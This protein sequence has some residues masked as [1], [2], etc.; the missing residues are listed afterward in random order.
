MNESGNLIEPLALLGACRETSRGLATILSPLGVMM[1]IDVE[2]NSKKADMRP[3]G[4]PRC[5]GVVKR[6]DASQ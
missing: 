6:L 2:G 1:S 4:R 5:H 3:A